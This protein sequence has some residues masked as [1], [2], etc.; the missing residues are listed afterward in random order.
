MKRYP[1]IFLIAGMA[2]A[3]GVGVLIVVLGLNPPAKDIQ[4]LLIF[5]GASGLVTM[6][7]AYL[8][9]KIGL[10]WWLPSLRWSLLINIAMTVLLV[11][12]NV[13]FT[14]QLMFISQHDFVLTT[15][16][17][18]FSGLTAMNFGLFVASTLT[19]RIHDLSSAAEQLAQGKLETRL[20]VQGND[21]LADFIKTF[22][23]MADSLQQLDREKRKIEQTR[24][25]LIAWVSHDLRTP[26]TSIRAMLEAI[27]DE[28]VTEP[29]DIKQYI[30]SSLSEIENLNLLI[31]DLFEL[32]KL[33]TGNLELK[34]VDASLRD[35]ISDVLSTLNA[36]ANK[37]HITLRGL[38]E[39]DIDPVYMAADKMQRVLYNLIDNALRYTPPNGE[40]TISTSV[41]REQVQI[42]VHNTGTYIAPEHLPHLFTSFYR[43]EPSRTHD[44]DGRRSTGL[45]LAIARGF[46][47]AHKG[48]IWVDSQPD[49]GTTFSFTIPRVRHAASEFR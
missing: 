10:V 17:L 9:N 45:G 43:A 29:D 21:E 14:A 8:F 22:N 44:K 40:I 16:L 5:M 25:D 15:A 36:Q 23:W 20:Q 37:H 1:L 26:L 41:F 19:S 6:L 42:N 3:L 38:I 12:L 39:Q 4:L 34:F 32:A 46:I 49:S 11:L 2:A 30:G 18:V 7:A 13:W 35:L 27:Q 47:E 33:D 24:R 48:K 31:E 28:V